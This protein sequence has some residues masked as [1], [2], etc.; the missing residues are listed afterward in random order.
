MNGNEARPRSAEVCVSVRKG[1]P[2]IFA[3]KGLKTVLSFFRQMDE[4]N[5]GWLIGI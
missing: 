3:K 4:S 5:R 1:A 2:A